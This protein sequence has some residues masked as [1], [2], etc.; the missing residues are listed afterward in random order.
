MCRY[1]YAHENNTFMERSKFV[2]TQAD[3]ANL[4]DRMQ[5]L[6]IVDICTRESQYKVEFLQIYSFNKFCFV[7]QSCTPGL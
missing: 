5:N 2:G 7:T 6:D 3:M 4:K 1:F